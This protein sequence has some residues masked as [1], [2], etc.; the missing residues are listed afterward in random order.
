[1]KNKI[2]IQIQGGV[3]QNVLSN[4]DVQV[5]LLDHDCNGES[6]TIINFAGEEVSTFDCY[7]EKNETVVNN[8]FELYRKG[9]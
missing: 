9:N 6:E 2:V 3:L 5:L 7:V 8:C 4:C 1:M